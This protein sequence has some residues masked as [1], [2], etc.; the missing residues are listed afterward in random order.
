[1]ARY[2]DGSMPLATAAS[3]QPPTAVMPATTAAP[4]LELLDLRRRQ[5]GQATIWATNRE[6][7]YVCGFNG[8][9]PGNISPALVCRG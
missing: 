5:A 8:G 6:S 3:D 4:D 1:M 2:G 7:N 9:D